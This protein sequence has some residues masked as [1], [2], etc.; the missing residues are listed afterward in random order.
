MGLS[1]KEINTDLVAKGGTSLGTP[2][3]YYKSSFLRTYSYKKNP[4][5]ISKKIS[6]RVFY[7]DDETAITLLH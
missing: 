3:N 5:K 1:L 4:S 6:P 2:S 7:S